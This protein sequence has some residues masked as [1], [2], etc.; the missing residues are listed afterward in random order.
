MNRTAAALLLSW[1]LPV[2]AQDAGILDARIQELVSR[3]EAATLE[4]RDRGRGTPMPG[5]AT[6]C[7]RLRT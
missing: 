2:A 3:Y 5:H 1:S 4:F 6:P 7:S